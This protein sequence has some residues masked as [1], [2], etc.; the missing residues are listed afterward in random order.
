MPALNLATQNS[1]FWIILVFSSLNAISKG[2]IAEDSGLQMY[3]A[4]LVPSRVQIRAKL[5]YNVFMMVGITILIWLVFTAMIDNFTGN[6]GYYLITIV[7]AG[8]G[9][10]STFTLMSALVK[11]LSNAFLII[12]VISLPIIIP[13]I[14]V[15]LK[16]S[17]K[18]LDDFSLS[19]I[20]QE[21]LVLAALSVFS[22]IMSEVL[23]V[24]LEK[25]T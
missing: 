6:T 23:Y 14:L 20:S 25:N 22:V 24:I 13:I 19:S 9:I 2:F 18:A 5:I 11:T 7:L 15:G 8:M 3:Y 1:F 4:Q 16:A 10:S 12:P 21:W 17:K